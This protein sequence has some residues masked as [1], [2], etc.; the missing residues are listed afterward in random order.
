MPHAL[1]VLV[2][3]VSYTPVYMI[4][5]VMGPLGA[6]LFLLIMRRIERVPALVA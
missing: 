3:H 4:V 6:V 5:G 2:E 1:A